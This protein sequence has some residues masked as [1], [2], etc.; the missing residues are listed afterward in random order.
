[1]NIIISFKAATEGFVMQ[2]LPHANKFKTALF[3]LLPVDRA[4]LQSM[5]LFLNAATENSWSGGPPI[6]VAT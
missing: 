4:P 3:E 2:C 6:Y 5:L 1:M